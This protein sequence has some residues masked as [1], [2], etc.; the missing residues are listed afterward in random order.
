MFIY[1]HPF[2]L[3]LYDS[4]NKETSN[5]NYLNSKNNNYNVEKGKNKYYN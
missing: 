4:E 3:K 1:A 2:I 5:Y